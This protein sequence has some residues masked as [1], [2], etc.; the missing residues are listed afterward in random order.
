MPTYVVVQFT[1]EDPVCYVRR[2]PARTPRQQ[3]A[4]SEMLLI[5]GS[6]A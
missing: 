6:A 1:V 3:S 5:E 2:A 4:S